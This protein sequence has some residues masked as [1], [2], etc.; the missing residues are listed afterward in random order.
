MPHLAE[1]TRRVYARVSEVHARELLGGVPVKL[2]RTSTFEDLKLTLPERDPPVGAETIRIAHDD[3][4]ERHGA[5]RARRHP[6][7]SHGQRRRCRAP[8]VAPR[9]RG[10]A[11]WPTTVEAIRGASWQTGTK[12]IRTVTM[13][14]QDAVLVSLLAY[15]GLRPKRR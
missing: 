11:I 3:A 10:L 13:A 5:R 7:D 4:A 12:R 6:S 1:N 9:R 8:T 14:E 2:A 15:A